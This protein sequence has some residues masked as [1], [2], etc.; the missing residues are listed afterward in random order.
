[1][2]GV[3]N[4]NGDYA[5]RNRRGGSKG[6]SSSNYRSGSGGGS[7]EC[8]YLRSDAVCRGVSYICE[9]DA[10][11]PKIGRANSAVIVGQDVEEGDSGDSKHGARNLEGDDVL[12]SEAFGSD[13]SIRAL[14]SSKGS[15]SGRDYRSFRTGMGKG[16]KVINVMSSLQTKPYRQVGQTRYVIMPATSELCRRSDPCD[17]GGDGG[18][19]TSL[20]SGSTLSKGYAGSAPSPTPH[21]DTPTR[22]P[23]LAPTPS[24]EVDV[25]CFLYVS[26]AVCIEELNLLRRLILYIHDVFLSLSNVLIKFLVLPFI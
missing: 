18:G 10:E 11:R 25:S 16:G 9:Q 23:T 24:C 13:E 8:I 6:D 5:D 26:P 3:E 19:G 20:R 2:T 4:G 1:M 17:Y 12:P 22:R 15:K 14:K 7:G 21:C